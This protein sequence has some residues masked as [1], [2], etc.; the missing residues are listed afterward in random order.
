MVSSANKHELA[1]AADHGTG[2]PGRRLTEVVD[3]FAKV[4]GPEER[5]AIEWMSLA[6][7]LLRDGSSLLLGDSP[8]FDADSADTGNV[9]GNPDLILCAKSFVGSNGAIPG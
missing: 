3:A 1:N 2:I 5:H 4:I 6:E 8:V 7:H 9:A